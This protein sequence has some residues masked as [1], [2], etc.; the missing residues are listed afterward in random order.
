MAYTWVKHYQDDTNRVLAYSY[1]KMDQLIM[2]HG[3][4]TK[5]MDKECCSYLLKLAFM[6]YFR[7][8][9]FM[10]QHL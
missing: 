1:G 7:Q 4:Q 10:D 5:L 6:P 8:I 3:N 9:N 2:D